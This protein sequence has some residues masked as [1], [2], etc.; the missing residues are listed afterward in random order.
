MLCNGVYTTI[1]VQRE[2]ILTCRYIVLVVTIDCVDT[3]V[4]GINGDG[5]Q[6]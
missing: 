6:C 2:M 3:T 1:F 4:G 5:N